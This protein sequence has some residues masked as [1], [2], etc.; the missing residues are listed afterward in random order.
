MAD[1]TSQ[2]SRY[3][4]GVESASHKN[5]AIEGGFAMLCHGMAANHFCVKC[6]QVI[7]CYITFIDI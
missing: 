3:W 6:L 5:L 2:N 4:I 7:G 1:L